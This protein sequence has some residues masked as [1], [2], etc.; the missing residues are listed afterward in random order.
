MKDEFIFLECP[1][2]LHKACNIFNN[3]IR[4][5]ITDI[6]EGL[7]SFIIELLVG[8]SAHQIRKDNL[9]KSF[10]I[11]VQFACSC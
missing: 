1:Q 5:V 11:F 7:S 9:R 4:I 10:I 2:Y 3:E 8:Q 6:F